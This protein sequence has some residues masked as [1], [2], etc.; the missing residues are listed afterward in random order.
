[1]GLSALLDQVIS[2]LDGENKVPFIRTAQLSAIQRLWPVISNL[3]GFI[4][5]KQLAERQQSS[6]QS[7]HLGTLGSRVIPQRSPM[8]MKSILLNC[9][10]ASPIKGYIF[11]DGPSRKQMLSP[12]VDVL[13][14]HLKSHGATRYLAV[15]IINEALHTEQADKKAGVTS[16]EDYAMAVAQLSSLTPFY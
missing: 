7:W 9:T 6:S 3:K 12:L 10:P 8:M 16:D 1:M 4:P 15:M 11:R 2:L 14:S 5:L 13:E